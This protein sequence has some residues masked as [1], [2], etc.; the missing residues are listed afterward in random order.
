MKNNSWYLIL[1]P[2]FFVL[3]GLVENFGFVGIGD[4]VLLCL[5]YLLITAALYLIAFLLL[6]LIQG[7]VS[8]LVPAAGVA[9][10]LVALI[11][12]ERVLIGNV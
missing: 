1:L 2:V 6:L 7:A 12:S 3:H 9:L 5:Y 8:P 11:F 4:S 10:V